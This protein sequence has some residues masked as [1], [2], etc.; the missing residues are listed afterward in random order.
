VAGIDALGYEPV[1]VWKWIGLAGVV[2]V[3]ALGVAGGARA[4]QRRRREFVD[5]DLEEV[6]RR[7]HDRHRDAV[8]RTAG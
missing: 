1:R 2:G 6:T 5:A 7:L 4:V 3:A 8:A